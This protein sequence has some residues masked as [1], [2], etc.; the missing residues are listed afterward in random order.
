MK[1]IIICIGLIFCLR[2]G[3]ACAQNVFVNGLEDIPIPQNVTQIESDNISFGNEETRLV[4][5]YLQ[6][7]Q[8][9]YGKIKAYY[10]ETLPQ[11]G[12]QFD[13]QKNGNLFFHRNTEN[14]TIAP[15]RQK[16]LLVR[17]TLTDKH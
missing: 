9:S 8:L 15:H 2:I 10:L 5:I 13:G 6:S 17:L 7:D 4:E 11:L 3:T 14:L 12:W 1:K 16:P